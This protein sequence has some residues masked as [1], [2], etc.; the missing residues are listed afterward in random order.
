MANR[1]VSPDGD[2]TPLYHASANGHTTAITE[3]LLHSPA[4]ER[5]ND[6]RT[7][8]LRAAFGGHEATVDLF[9]A[10]GADPDA[11]AR[12]DSRNRLRPHPNRDYLY[13]LDE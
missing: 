13:S 10:A 12:D 7:P 9:L 2:G 11:T 1:I 8:L 4:L 6:N 5:G 3:L